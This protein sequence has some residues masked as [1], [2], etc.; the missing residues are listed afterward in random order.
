MKS[1]TVIFICLV[2]FFFQASNVEGIIVDLSEKDMQE[3]IDL[4]EQQKSN[5]TKYLKKKYLFKE[6]SPIESYGEVRTKWSKL[7]SI[8]GSYSADGKDITKEQGKII[9]NFTFFQVDLYTHGDKQNFYNNYEVYLIQKGKLIE[10]EKIK[11]KEITKFFKMK[12]KNYTRHCVMITSYFAYEKIYPAEIAE[13][14]LIKGKDSEVF[15]LNL[16]DYR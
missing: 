10:P 1:L 9:T 14:V 7:A 8:A 11:K 15:K 2:V 4:G 13:L 6:E 12:Y 5:V 16:A 3:A